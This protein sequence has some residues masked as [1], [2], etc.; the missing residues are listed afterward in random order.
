MS[1]VALGTDTEVSADGFPG[2]RWT[3]SVESIADAL[4]PRRLRPQDPS[5]PTD[6]AVLPVRVSLPPDTPLKLG[7]RVSVLFVRKP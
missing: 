5:R 7:Q 3:G 6:S 4:G 1:P 2:A